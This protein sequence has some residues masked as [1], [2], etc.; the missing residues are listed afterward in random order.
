M[1]AVLFERL[2]CQ[3]TA[4][5]CQFH[6]THITSPVVIALNIPNIESFEPKCEVRLSQLAEEQIYS[7]ILT[8]R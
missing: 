8:Q 4:T 6:D 1:L 5:Q 7:H 3:E 2:H